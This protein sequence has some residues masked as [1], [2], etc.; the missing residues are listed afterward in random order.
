M[1][2]YNYW[3]QVTMGN[4]HDDVKKVADYITRDVAQDGLAAAIKKLLV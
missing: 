4:A 2:C 1:K 3:G